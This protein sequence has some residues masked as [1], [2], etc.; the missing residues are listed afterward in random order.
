MIRQVISSAALAIELLAVVAIVAGV[1][2]V[3]LSRST[4]RNVFQSDSFE[5]YKHCKTLFAKPLLLGLDLLVAAD[6]VHTVAVEPNLS[7]V[8]V[9]GLILL[10]RTFVSWSMAVDVE[11]HW[12]W[13]ASERVSPPVQR[14]TSTDETGAKKL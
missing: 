8:A 4:I 5:A 6:I 3:T 9:L 10:M 7:N 2:V 14:D 13:K 1:L 12:P 11:G